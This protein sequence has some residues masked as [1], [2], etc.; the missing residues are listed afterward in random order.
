MICP[1]CGVES[2]AKRFC[3][4]CGSALARACPS[5]GRSVG[6]ADSFCG[7]CGADLRA[8]T[9]ER[10]RSQTSPAPQ[11]RPAEASLPSSER[12]HVSVLFA[13]LVG[14]SLLSGQRDAEDVRE[15]LSQ[16]FATARTVIG[17]Y[18]GT[19]E[20]FIGDA[21]MAVWGVPL[22]QEDD[23]ERAVRAALELV[24]AV[25][26]F[27]EAVG[28][29]GLRARAGVL[30]GE[31]AVNLGVT[32]EGMVAGDMVNMASRVQSAAPPGTVLVGEA[33]WR[34]TT[35]AIRYEDAGQHEL[36][37][38]PEPVRLW[39]A[40]GVVAA[41]G[42]ALRPTGLEARF[43]GR[44]RELRV[45]KE[46]LHATSEEGKARLL[47][48]IGVGGVGKSRLAWEFEKYVDGLSEG[49]WWHRG[50]C[51][52]YGEGVAYSALAEMVR[53]RA[54]I[55]ENEAADSARQKLQACV[56]SFL[57]DDAE[58]QWVEPRLAHLL[59]LEDLASSDPRDLYAAWRVFFERLAAEGL[60][61]LLFGDLQW[62]DPGLFDF[63]DYLLD[64]S[65]SSPILV[66]TLSRPELADRRPGWGTGKR[67]F[68]SLYLEPLSDD[69][70]T[71]LLEGLVPGLPAELTA[72]VKERAAGIPLYAME[73]VRMLLDRGLVVEREG[74]YRAVGPLQELEVPESLHALIAARLDSLSIGE[75]QLVQ[76]AAVLGK[77]FTPAALAAITGLPAEEVEPRLRALADKDL[78]AIQ[79]DPRSPERGQ[80]IFVQDLV[81]TVAYGTLARRE[82]K[83][84][85]LAVA[86]YMTSSWGDEDDIAEVVAS[87]LME[88][89]EADPNAPDAGEIGA[90]AR[91]ALGRAASHA[92]SLG[93]PESACRYYERALELADDESRADLH[94]KAGV[95]ARLLGQRERAR[96]HLE[97]ARDL[98]L[99]AGQ[100]LRQ[101]KALG[102]LASVEV[103]SGQRELSLQHFDEALTLLAGAPADEETA[104]LTA[105]FEMRLARALLFAL[106]PDGALEHVE[107]SLRLAERGQ[108]W[109]VLVSGLDTKGG[110]FVTLGRRVEGEALISVALRVAIDHEVTDSAAYG[111]MS[112]ATVL[113]EVDLVE[114]SLMAYE[115][116]EELQQRLGDRPALVGS[117]LNRIPGLIELGRWDE[118]EA[119]HN[120]YIEVE[121][122]ELGVD[123][124]LSELVV[125]SVWLYER[126][127]DRAS[128]H[129]I[130]SQ[131]LRKEFRPDLRDLR[132]CAQAALMNGDGDHAAALALAE[133]VLKSSLVRDLAT[134]RLA[135]IEAV[136]AAFAL[137]DL[138]KVEELVESF[139]ANVGPGRQPSIDAHVSR[140]EARLAAERGDHDAA[141]ARFRS[142]GDAFALL[143]RPFWLAVTRLE[144]AESLIEQRRDAEA[145]ELLTPALTTF[146]QLR[147]APWVER[148]N[149]A[150]R[151]AATS[152]ERSIPA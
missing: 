90:R 22:S 78:L 16:Y 1:S 111:Y 82:R 43:V 132:D 63:I 107:R 47:S 38:K 59:G 35:A 146:E 19:I 140:W 141:G 109:N 13:D 8:G 21:V 3:I 128:A 147:A 89:Y 134:F 12:R 61:V 40:T 67:A 99:A 150:A 101:A 87:H 80:Y 122:P 105:E 125:G 84:R 98:Y 120:Q 41:R 126:R 69:A 5:C 23:A 27:G 74:V 115:Q 14:F 110:I 50:R 76:D 53:M 64:W 17:R 10:N 129:R 52:S 55:A 149:A 28:V 49:I 29:P 136:D 9:A 102:E 65:R 48:I 133:P 138:A 127:G 108:L 57:P 79:S 137:G 11:S 62:A 77:S 93:A 81:R 83:L 124:D 139:H 142:A 130:V 26:A 123:W 34:A 143:S 73:T 151:R 72:R 6:A 66:L 15:L 94:L 135:I 18:G 144:H 106:D 42:G 37:G 152:R 33:T 24:D 131:Y 112:L 95:A 97:E 20:K 119:I 75:R 46:L 116:S 71:E 85:H 2:Q 113:E 31:A 92:N 25:G 117:R 36:K 148:A 4:N 60:T 145:R 118:A 100:T 32:G 121:M 88:A 104:A 86:D 7:E 44:D 96:G 39:R 68:T 56:Q 45:L 91:Q 54:G 30:T 51:L 114:R 58:R 103:R 70:M